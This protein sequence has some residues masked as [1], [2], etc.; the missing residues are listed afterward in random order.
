MLKKLNSMFRPHTERKLGEYGGNKEWQ[1]EE[2]GIRLV[3]STSLYLIRESHPNVGS[4]LKRSKSAVNVDSSIYNIKAEDRVWMFSRT[5]DCLQYLQDLIVLRQQYRPVSNLN[6]PKENRPDPSSAS[7][8][9]SKPVKKAS[10][11]KHIFKQNAKDESNP[12]SIPTEADTLAYFDSV[13]AD[14]DQE[15]KPKVHLA[16]DM[17][18]DVD[19]V[20]ATS[21][22]EHS[23][24][25]NWI[26]KSPRRYS[27]DMAH[28]TKTDHLPRRHSDGMR[29]SFKRFER[30]PMYLPKLV[31]SPIHTLRFK[32]KARNEDDEF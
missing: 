10:A 8:K 24:H 2:S 29:M 9:P 30:H 25:S 21:T 4:T 13:I 11:P 23:L 12:A 1:R 5:Q 6:K 19:F 27:I 28:L 14:F 16:E 32:P 17:H 22:S 26:L 7:N 31:E 3:R 20:I 15:N 18:L